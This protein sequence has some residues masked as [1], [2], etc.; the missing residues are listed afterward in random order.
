MPCWH[1]G[2]ILVPNTRGGL[3]AG[4]SPFTAMTNIII[5]EFKFCQ[6]IWVKL[7]CF[8]CSDCV[9]VIL[10]LFDRVFFSKYFQVPGDSARPT[11]LRLGDAKENQRPAVLSVDPGVLYLLHST[12]HQVQLHL[13]PVQ[14]LRDDVWSVLGVSLVL[15]HH[16]CLH[17]SSLR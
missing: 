15:Y 6:I 3:V 8:H 1:Y 4:S 17:T 7:K 11:L 10:T 9:F 5:T 16:C 2:R 14:S 12:T 13:L